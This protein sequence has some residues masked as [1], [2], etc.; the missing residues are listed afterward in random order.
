MIPEIDKSLIFSAIQK[1]L[2]ENPD[3]PMVSELYGPLLE[4][5]DKGDSEAL[6]LAL[7]MA[8]DSLAPK[9]SFFSFLKRHK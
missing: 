3:C 7:Q 4:R 6:E 5:I 8:H 2:S 1:E 9:K